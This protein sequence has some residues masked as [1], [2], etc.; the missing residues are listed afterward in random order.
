MD[1]W[2]NVIEHNAHPPGGR[3]VLFFTIWFADYAMSPLSLSLSQSLWS[4]FLFVCT[5][6]M[7]NVRLYHTWRRKC[8]CAA[9][10][11]RRANLTAVVEVKSIA[12]LTPRWSLSRAH[13]KQVKL[14]VCVCKWK[15]ERERGEENV[16][17]KKKRIETEEWHNGHATTNSLL[18]PIGWQGRSPS[19]IKA[20]R[21]FSSTNEA[22]RTKISSSSTAGVSSFAPPIP[23]DKG[24]FERDSRDLMDFFLLFF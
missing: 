5:F 21:A 18:R 6:R 9:A 23:R 13:E 2:Q 22:R 4:L 10:T 14:C 20:Q 12:L 3:A 7:S 15:R 1:D 16:R 17:M 19:L 8:V 24:S 11:F